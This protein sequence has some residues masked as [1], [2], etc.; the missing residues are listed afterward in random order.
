M[1]R[2]LTVGTVAGLLS[3]LAAPALASAGPSSSSALTV[4]DNFFAPKQA[5]LELDEGSFDWRWGPDGLGTA[6]LHNVV[7]DD[8]LF[9]SGEVTTNDPDG[10]S[11]TASAGKYPYFCEVHGFRGGI[12][13]AGVVSVRPVVV[14][15]LSERAARG[16][17]V[18]WASDETT[19]GSKFDV[20]YKAGK[21]WKLWKKRTSK[22]SG[23]FGRKGK[24]VK[25]K[26]KPVKLQ[27]RSVG[28]KK[29]RSGWS[30]TLKLTR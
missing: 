2:F 19:T 24:P 4:D 3:A 18:A 11:V 27:A 14:E 13:M 6:N 23:V 15:P 30:P 7:Q 12:G 16:V 17:R 22:T 25:L 9:D 20:R 5:A 21:K 26:R 29:K 1:K 8:G 10:F 28:G